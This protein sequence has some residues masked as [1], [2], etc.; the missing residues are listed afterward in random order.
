[1]EAGFSLLGKFDKV[2]TRS[3]ELEY[4][5]VGHD[6]PH[7]HFRRRYCAGNP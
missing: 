1:M 2:C 3:R 6:G 7:C 5:G 4:P